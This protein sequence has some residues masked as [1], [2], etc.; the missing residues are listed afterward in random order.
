MILIIQKQERLLCL[1]KKT[2]LLKSQRDDKSR[3]TSSNGY[4]VR[5]VGENCGCCGEVDYLCRGTMLETRWEVGGGGESGCYQYGQGPSG[6]CV[7]IVL[8][9]GV[10]ATEVLQSLIALTIELH[11]LRW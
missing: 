5:A 7:L 10:A 1:N 3:D 6:T 4:A 8:T 2:K 9:C 11:G